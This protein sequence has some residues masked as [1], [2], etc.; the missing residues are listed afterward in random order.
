MERFDLKD[1]EESDLEEVET[2]GVGNGFEKLTR[3]EYGPNN[4]FPSSPSRTAQT[5]E[6]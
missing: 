3:F 2:S 5:R 1:E 4:W 6:V